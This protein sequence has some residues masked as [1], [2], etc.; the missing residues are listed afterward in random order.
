MTEFQAID[1]IEEYGGKVV[2][3][4]IKLPKVEN[5]HTV[6]AYNYLVRLGYYRLDYKK[7]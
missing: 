5:I 6:K 4:S 1:I 7:V 2:C 3:K